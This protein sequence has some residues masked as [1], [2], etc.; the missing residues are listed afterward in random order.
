MGPARVSVPIAT[1]DRIDILLG[2]T[3]PA[4]LGQT[5]CDVEVIIVGDGTPLSL[6]RRLEAA[7]PDQVLAERLRRRTRYPKYPLERWMV[8]GWRPRRRAARLATGDWLLWISDDDILLPDGVEKLLE[9][10]RRNAAVEAIT[11]AYYVGQSREVI[12][13]PRDGLS[14]LSFEASGMPAF[15]VRADL[16]AV[17]WNRHSWRKGWNRPSDYDLMDRLHR[18]GVRWGATE[19]IV[20]VVPEVEGTGQ[21]GSRGFAL[22]RA[23]NSD[24]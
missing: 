4:L 16:S 7:L 2:R 21:L 1:Y 13:S 19:A 15:L 5:H 12:R 23:L 22:D 6:W 11:G 14:G 20:A 24:D 17:R 8:A 18:A 9:V 3:L 10:A